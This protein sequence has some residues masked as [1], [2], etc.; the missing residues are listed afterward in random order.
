MRIAVL[1]T[2]QG[3]RIPGEKGASLHLQSL[4]KA[5][6]AIGHQ[7]LLIGVEGHGKRPGFCTTLLLPHPGRADGLLR[8][9]NKLAIT[10]R[11]VDVAGPA[12]DDF[13]PDIIYERLALF[14]TAG[15]RLAKR[16]AA[17]HVIEVNA[18]LAKEEA[19]WREFSL[20]ETAMQRE[21]EVLRTADCVV[22][23]SAE[24]AQQVSAIR[25]DGGGHDPAV[26]VVPNGFDEDVF[27][28]RFDKRSARIE[29]GLPAEARVVLFSGALRPWH[30]LDTA[31]S[32][33]EG[34]PSNV[35]LVVAGD[36]EI[37]LHLQ[38]R[39]E[40]LGVA[41]RIMWLGHVAHPMMPRLL[42][43]ADV[44]V[45][46]YPDLSGFAFSPLK[47]Y[48]Y[49]AAGLPIVASRIGQVHELLSGVASAVLSEPG[50]PVDL[51]RAIRLVIENPTYA[52]A[53][54]GSRLDAFAQHGWQSRARQ[55]I[56]IIDA[57]SAT[58][59]A[60]KGVRNVLR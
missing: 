53:A 7:V 37:R 44:G 52:S 42:A 51:A 14:G 58:S 39:A 35:V 17:R 25:T 3:V 38:R 2:D 49:L 47:L 28:E 45:A 29:F 20:V 22:A 26:H 15:M 34:L 56:D 23:V 9:Q 21:N 60:G 16:I 33:L 11:F 27:Q 57:Q 54:K 41:H 8:E 36:G 32:S 46:P 19:E 4:A 50:D 13:A 30:G 1:C 10:E 24:W 40:N 6:T 12:L 18:L 5:F 48:E 31:I 59:L 55:I 43:A